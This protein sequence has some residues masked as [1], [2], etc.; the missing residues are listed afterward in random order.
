MTINQSGMSKA[1]LHHDLRAPTLDH[2]SEAPALA[3]TL[4]QLVRSSLQSGSRFPHTLLIGPPDSGKQS[5][6][7]TIAAELGAPFIT[8]PAWTMH[9]RVELHRILDCA[10]EGAVVLVSLIEG[11]WNAS[12]ELLRFVTG[13]PPARHPWFPADIPG[14]EW[15][16]TGAAERRSDLTI[17]ATSRVRAAEH[18]ACNQWAELVLYTERNA[19]TEKQ[20]ID[21]MLRRSGVVADADALDLLANF[22]VTAKVRTLRLARFVLLWARQTGRGSIDAGAAE[23]AIREVKSLS[24]EATRADIPQLSAP[25]AMSESNGE[26]RDPSVEISIDANPA[27]E[28]SSGLTNKEAIGLVLALV[29]IVTAAVFAANA[30]ERVVFGAGTPPSVPGQADQGNIGGIPPATAG[31]APE[32]GEPPAL[33][34]R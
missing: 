26:P 9:D 30:L 4:M 14:E 28:Q 20:R 7:A 23:H 15:K 3:S 10:P 32:F 6:A 17:I 2:L 18:F 13:L 19:I 22:G 16:S 25:P 29:A 21:R 11:N 24:P 12:G 34:A 27:G 8:V 31:T 1:H 5:I 33:I